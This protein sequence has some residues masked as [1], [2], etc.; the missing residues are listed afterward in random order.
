MTKPLSLV[1]SELS[2]RR[3]AS[4]PCKNDEHV[5]LRFVSWNEYFAKFWQLMVEEL[6]ECLFFYHR[7]YF[8]F[9]F[10]QERK[11]T[12]PTDVQTP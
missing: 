4:A 5:S 7:H 11:P 6:P 12:K 8:I 9:F 2:M 1:R 10:K 3:R